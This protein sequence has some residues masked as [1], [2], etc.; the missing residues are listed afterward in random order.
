VILNKVDFFTVVDLHGLSKRP[1]FLSSK[2]THNLLCAINNSVTIGDTMKQISD[3]DHKSNN[4]N[5][6]T[7]VIT[8]YEVNVQIPIEHS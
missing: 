1:K 7:I 4:I 5:K 8:K 6:S 3:M 2:F